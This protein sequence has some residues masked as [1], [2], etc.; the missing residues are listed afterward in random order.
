MIIQDQEGNEE[1][2]PKEGKL[3]VEKEERKDFDKASL[4]SKS[5]TRQ[6]SSQK[7]RKAISPENQE[8]KSPLKKLLSGAT[9]GEALGGLSGPSKIASALSG[10]TTFKAV[11]RLNTKMK[12]F[13]TKLN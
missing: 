12:E 11:H 1:K 10:A 6:K 4:R 13:E 5:K 8:P 3:K 7:D 2:D 9:G